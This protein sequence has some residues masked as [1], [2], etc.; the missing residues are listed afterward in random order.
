MT[1]QASG[2]RTRDYGLEIGTPDLESIGPIAFGPESILFLADNLGAA[3]V[4]VAVGDGEAAS[5]ASPVNVD[6]LDT[7][8][9]AYLGCSRDDVFIRDMAVH[10]STHEVY[11]SVT[12][13]SGAAAIALLITVAS[14]GSLSEVPLKE[15]SFARTA[16]EDAP[17]EGDEREDVRLVQDD[18][19]GED[20]ETS[21]GDHMR[22]ARE[23]LRT[24]T[25]TDM[26]YV[27]GV[28]LVAGAS[29]EEFASTLRRIPFPFNGD[30]RANSLE[31]YHVSHG[32]Y[33]TASP[34]RTFVPY[35]DTQSVLASYTCTPVVHF[36][37]DDLQAG[38]QIM[39]RTVA[40]LGSMSTP[41]DMVSYS[42]DGEEYL[43]VS[44]TH[45]PLT[46]IAS[47]D[48]PTQEALTEPQEPVGVPRQ[49]LPH[50]GVGRMA[51]LGGGHVVM[52]QQDDEGNL[53]LQSYPCATL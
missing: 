31:I 45:N 46:K 24:L 53:D 32:K 8:L 10:P 41:I 38:T 4:A 25:V 2:I 5:E 27:D 14:D 36:A 39:G 3:I 17:T 1:G 19:E 6:K 34:I 12:R 52:I 40:E 43:L 47:R 49:A 7:R 23:R 11:L 50:E 28:L 20:Y 16:I 9:A 48:I 21:S 37:L 18:R 33:E 13:G 51:N 30:S 26:S 15:V 35:G 29:N 42:S 44:N 22:L